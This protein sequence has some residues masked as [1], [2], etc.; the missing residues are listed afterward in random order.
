MHSITNGKCDND[1]LWHTVAK[2]FFK[3]LSV[4]FRDEVSTN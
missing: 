3:L 4:T 1:I 2:N